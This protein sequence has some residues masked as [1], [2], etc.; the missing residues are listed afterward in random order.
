MDDGRHNGIMQTRK[1][2]TV[3]FSVPGDWNADEFMLE[4]AGAYDEANREA[5]E[6]VD[7]LVENVMEVS[8]K[9]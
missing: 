2:I 7:Y 5:A 8:V 1:Q 3:S 4:L 9:P 6:Q